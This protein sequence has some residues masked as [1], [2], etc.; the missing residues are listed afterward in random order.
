MRKITKIIISQVLL[1]ALF[2]A[3]ASADSDKASGVKIGM[4][5]ANIVGRDAEGVES[6]PSFEFGA[7]HITGLNEFLE[8]QTELLYSQKGA[9]IKSQ[10]IEEGIPVGIEEKF[11]LNYLEFPVLIKFKVPGESSI[12]PGI[13]TGMAVGVTISSKYQVT[14]TASAN[15]QSASVTAEQDLEDVNPI[16]IGLVFGGSMSLKLGSNLLILDARYTKGLSQID[17]SYSGSDSKNSVFSISAGFAFPI[18]R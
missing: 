17:N 18:G 8:I 11:K 7:F 16:D 10:V 14:A 5:I 12:T 1:L 2:V 13:Y 3:T 6:M 15:G 9:M 4:N